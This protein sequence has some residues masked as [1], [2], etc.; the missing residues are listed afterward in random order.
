M[1]ATSTWFQAAAFGIM[2][3]GAT[4]TS[5][6]AA[7]I[8]AEPLYYPPPGF[9]ATATPVYYEGRPA[10]YYNDHWYFQTSHGWSYYRSEPGFLYRQRVVVGPPAHVVVRARVR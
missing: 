7:T 10:Y 9:L 4:A 2:V 5:G 6:C 3:A 1:N 8:V